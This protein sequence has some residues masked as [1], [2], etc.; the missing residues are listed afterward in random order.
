MP[1]AWGRRE[2]AE[3]GGVPRLR[4]EPADGA[5]P[6]RSTPLS[7]PARPSHRRDFGDLPGQMIENPGGL[8]LL[9][10]DRSV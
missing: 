7:P 6:W 3:H 4:V 5:P 10:T 2:L 9:S 8:V 1:G